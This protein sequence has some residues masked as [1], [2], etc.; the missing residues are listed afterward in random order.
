MLGIKRHTNKKIVPLLF[1]NGCLFYPGFE[2]SRGFL[3]IKNMRKYRDIN[4]EQ[5]TKWISY[6]ERMFGLKSN[7]L[8]STTRKKEIVRPRHVCYYLMRKNNMTFVR[9]ANLFN[10]DHA[11]IIH[12]VES[13]VF[14]I[15]PYN[16][17]DPKKI[18]LV[19]GYLKFLMGIAAFTPLDYRRD[20]SNI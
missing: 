20:V 11:T 9:I 6:A 15:I 4:E 2:R 13:A 1:H 10:K 5:F 12:G 17:I 8:V 14:T 3:S 18:E 19:E 16:E 7:T